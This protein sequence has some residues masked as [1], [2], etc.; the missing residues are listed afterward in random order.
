M[1]TRRRA[2]PSKKNRLDTIYAT[3]KTINENREKVAVGTLSEVETEI[4]EAKKA[5]E[6][7]DA[8]QISVALDKLTRA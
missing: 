4:A 7:N 3:E 8:A 6:S 5:V 2:K 1:M